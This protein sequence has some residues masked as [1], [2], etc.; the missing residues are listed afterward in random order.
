[1]IPEE[2]EEESEPEL[3]P[4]PAPKR[5]PKPAPKAASK[6][7]SKT[8]LKASRS[9]RKLEQIEAPVPNAND[10]VETIEAETPHAADTSI[11]PAKITLPVSDTPVINRNKEMRKKGGGTRRSSLGMRGRRASSLI[12]SGHNAIPHHEVATSEFYKHISADGL[13]E[14]RRMKQ[15]LTWCGERALLAKPQHGSANANV[16]NGGKS[17]LGK[18]TSKFLSQLTFTAR[19]IQDQLL[20]EFANRSECSDWFSRDD[21]EPQRKAPVVLEENPRNKEHR[22]KIEQL[23][24]KVK[25]FLYPTAP[26][27]D[28]MLTLFQVARR[29]EGMACLEEQTGTR[30][31]ATLPRATLRAR[32]TAGPSSA[33]PQVPRRERDTDA[34][35]PY[36]PVN[37]V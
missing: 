17:C 6:T 2:Q 8:A 22:E 10:V 21:E 15:L 14:P 18:L 37:I 11:G 35:L 26:R 24:A 31:A 16:V 33:G 19:A 34:E 1:M 29:K 25:R 5:A 27:G 3:E 9:K 28:G 36:G 13:S 12:D 7:A 20:K 32:A 23:E 30:D 4:A